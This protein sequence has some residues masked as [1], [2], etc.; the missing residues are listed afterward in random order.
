MVPVRAC[1]K[2]A[3][4]RLV[5]SAALRKPRAYSASITEK[6]KLTDAGGVYPPL[7]V[8][9][10]AALATAA[11]SLTAVIASSSHAWAVRSLVNTVC[12]AL[13]RSV[14]DTA[15]PNLKPAGRTPAA[16]PIGSK[17][18]RSNVG[19]ASAGGSLAWVATD[20]TVKN[21]CTARMNARIRTAT[22]PAFCAPWPAGAPG[23]AA[24]VNG[25]SHC[26]LPVTVKNAVHCAAVTCFSVATVGAGVGGDVV[27]G[28]QAAIWSA[29]VLGITT[30]VT[31]DP[32]CTS[33]GTPVP[34]MTVVAVT[35]C[36]VVPAA[37][38]APETDIPAVMPSVLP[39]PKVSTEVFCPQSAVVVA[40]T[41]SNMMT[42]PPGTVARTPMLSVTVVEVSFWTLVPGAIFGPAT[43]I[44]LLML[45]VPAGPLKVSVTPGRDSAV[46][47]A[48]TGAIGVA[49]IMKNVTT[50][51]L[52]RSAETFALSVT[53]VAVTLCTVVPAAISG[54]AADIPTLIQLAPSAPPKVS[55]A[56]PDGQSAV[57]VSVT[58]GVA[59]LN[60]S[61]APAGTLPRTCLLSVTAV[62]GTPWTVVPAPMPGPD[63]C[64]P[65]LI[66]L[67]APGPKVSTLPPDGQSAVVPAV[68][69]ANVMIEPAGTSARTSVLSVTVAV[70]YL[71]V[72]PGATFGPD[73][74]IPAPIP[75]P[76]PKVSTE[77]E[78][79]PA[80]VDAANGVMM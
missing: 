22:L 80:M 28:S 71:T 61:T 29:S 53:V 36:T 27:E 17:T 12:A 64:I 31:T 35:L 5:M 20:E 16:W 3:P 18:G 75:V 4:E 10:L 44:P 1:W 73:T 11:R 67:A 63:R 15:L 39:E 37:M 45:F 66:P 56:V 2:S 23:V 48:V 50:E 79:V 76:A 21:C 33:A 52:G 70:T 59:K 65:A 57:V 41:G 68:T 38:P 13:V 58:G 69:G 77:P 74:G 55:R 30:N 60:T 47:V 8:G 19:G 49:G 9:A 6:L 40:V 62:G 46:V 72:V 78:A 7:I 51:L 54:P 25:G 42:E 32:L 34:R 14:P 26:G 24:A 43:G